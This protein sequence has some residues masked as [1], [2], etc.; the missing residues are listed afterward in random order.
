MI[1]LQTISGCENAD[2]RGDVIFV[3]GLGGHPQTTWH[4]QDKEDNQSWLYWLGEDLKDT[5]IWSFGYEAEFSNWKGKAMPRFD[6]ARNFIQWLE[7]K[8]LGKEQPL[9]FITH[10]LGGLLVKEVVR[11]ADTYGKQAFINQLKGIVFL[12]TPHN[13]SHLA[14]TVGILNKVLRTTVSVE[15]LEASNPWLRDIDAWYRQKVGQFRITTQVYYETQETLRYKVVDE[16][17]ADPKILDVMPIAVPADHITIAKPRSRQDL[18]YE[19]VKNFIQEHLRPLPQLP[20]ADSTPLPS[21]TKSPVWQM[22]ECKDP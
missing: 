6:Q 12:A 11:L 18:V 16:G 10:S 7:N 1:G 5:G 2:R 14:N 9:I 15:E 21:I 19:G 4:P 13:G 3:H 17:S 22:E 8:R 20:P